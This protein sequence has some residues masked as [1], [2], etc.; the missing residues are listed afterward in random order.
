MGNVIRSDI[1]RLFR[2][3]SLYIIMG[4]VALLNFA[5]G[6]VLKILFNLTKSLASDDDVAEMGGF[7]SE[8]KFSTILSESLGNVDTVFVLLVVIWFAYADL[9]HGYVKNIAG[10][11]SKKGNIVISK[12]AVTA[13]IFL[14]LVHIEVHNLDP[15][16]RT[17]TVWEIICLALL[18]LSNWL[19]LNCT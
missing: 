2:Q 19:G 5:E 14:H 7:M 6:P 17:W 12:T 13:F 16:Q 3:K 18:D 15:P 10:Q 1:Y 11:L 9:A 8:M 4:I